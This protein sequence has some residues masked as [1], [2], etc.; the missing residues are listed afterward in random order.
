MPR[1]DLEDFHRAE[2]QLQRDLQQFE[3]NRE[4][5]SS[6]NKLLLQLI[7][8]IE[9]LQ[10]RVTAL[11]QYPSTTEAIGFQV[12]N[13]DEDEWEEPICPTCSTQ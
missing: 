11:E 7:K 4:A 12:P 5:R 10:E 2:I 3:A 8:D 9:D 13:Q 6:Y 1:P